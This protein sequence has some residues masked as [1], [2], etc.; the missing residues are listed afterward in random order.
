MTRRRLLLRTLFFAPLLAAGTAEPPPEAVVATLPFA[1]SREANRVM[2]DLAPEGGRPFLMLLDTGA[3]GSVV[4][5]R[6][7][8]E[9]GVRV[10]KLKDTPYRRATRLGRDLQFWVDTSS[11]D[12]A[13]RT[14]SEYSLLGGEFL[15]DYVL[16]IDF[17]GRRVRLL[18]PKRY[19]V[20]EAA[21][22][23]G[24]HVVA[25]RRQ[26]TRIS[27]PIRANGHEL[28]VLL[29]TGDP[30]AGVL[31]GQ[32][33]REAGIDVDALPAFGSV[34][35]VLGE[36]RTSFYEEPHFELGGIAL[37]PVPLLVAPKGCTTRAG[38][39]TRRSAT[40]CWRPS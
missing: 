28:Y 15:D 4:T 18:D 30:G 19:A 1:P 27:V 13:S 22:E 25:L 2:V 29:D 3:S 26:A 24:E 33:A 5:P 6:M 35:T 7:A 38:P 14:G 11:S 21:E 39:T 20:P 12:T 23:P 16:E 9:L 31:S 32:A 17:P 8:R 34:G 37:G 40:T 36:M 10:R